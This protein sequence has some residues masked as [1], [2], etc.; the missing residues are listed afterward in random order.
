MAITTTNPD[1]RQGFLVNATSSDASSTEVVLAGIAGKKT[2]IRHLT[3]N[4][5]TAGALSFTLSG[6]AALIG[7][8]SIGANSTVQW[9]FNPLLE[10]AT[11]QDL[12]ITADAGSVMVFAQGFIE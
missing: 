2:K 4:N 10:L 8:I 3:M 5:L 7:P 11:A 9:N 1:V 6:S 12:E